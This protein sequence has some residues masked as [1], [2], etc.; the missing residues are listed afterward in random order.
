MT[1][2]G[3]RDGELPIDPAVKQEEG[4]PLTQVETD[5][6]SAGMPDSDIVTEPDGSGTAGGASGSSGGGS[7]LP[8]HPDAPPPRG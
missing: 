7:S 2:Q 3:N 4:A 8:G 1:K 6:R 5:R